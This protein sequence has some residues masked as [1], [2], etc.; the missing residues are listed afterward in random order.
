MNMNSIFIT[1]TNAQIQRIYP[2]PQKFPKIQFKS[3]QVTTVNLRL[4][5]PDFT[6]HCSCINV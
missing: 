1:C 6:F 2:L 4:E 5:K 3:S